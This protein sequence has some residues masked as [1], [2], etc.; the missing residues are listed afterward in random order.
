MEK[1]DNPEV[2][3]G[4]SI[5]QGDGLILVMHDATPVARFGYRTKRY[6]KSLPSKHKALSYAKSLINRRVN[7]IQ[8][9][10][11]HDL[12]ALLSGLPVQVH[13][14]GGTIHLV[15]LPERTVLFS[16][17]YSHNNGCQLVATPETY[18]MDEAAWFIKDILLRSPKLLE[19]IR[20]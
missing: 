14:K 2:Y 17:F 8:P 3:N 13:M 12:K 20:S 1:H 4:Y 6:G 15:T 10:E 11:L 7:K 5:Y 18:A 19:A 9:A 16:T